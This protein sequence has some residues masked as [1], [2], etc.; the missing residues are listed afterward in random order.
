MLGNISAL[1]IIILL[2]LRQFYRKLRLFTLIPALLLII[3]L[4][5]RGIEIRYIPLTNMYEALTIFAATILLICFY[6]DKNQKNYLLTNW[7]LGFSLVLLVF[8]STPLIPKEINTPV[9]ALQSNWLLFHVLITFIGQSCLAI[10]AIASVISLLNKRNYNNAIVGF[11]KIG[12]P[13]YFCGAIILGSIWASSAWGAFWRW[14]PKETW[15][16]ITSLIYTIYVHG[17][18]VGYIKGKW[19]GRLSIIGFLFSL[20]TFF[21]VNLLL[22]SIHSY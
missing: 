17:I 9:P 21:G 7:G 20:F 1:T 6:I 3:D 15:A 4:I 8:L 22:D 16:L 19:V 14:D 13:L 12:Y 2:V 10:S 18:K 11:I 5:I